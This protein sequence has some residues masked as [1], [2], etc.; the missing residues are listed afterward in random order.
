MKMHA[1]EAK[2]MQ[3]AS[4]HEGK[5]RENGKTSKLVNKNQM[6]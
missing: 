4:A 5:C 1:T 6:K 3:T 2:V